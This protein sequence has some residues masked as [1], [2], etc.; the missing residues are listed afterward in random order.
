MKQ[1][2]K[3]Y[4]SYRQ[5]FIRRDIDLE[6]RKTKDKIHL[7][8]RNHLAIQSPQLAHLDAIGRLS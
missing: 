4:F 7:S 1:Q 5:D 8:G 6:A 3:I 2:G